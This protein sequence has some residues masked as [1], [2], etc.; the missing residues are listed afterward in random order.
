V[1]LLLDA[2]LTCR[3]GTRDEELGYRLVKLHWEAAHFDAVKIAYDKE[4]P[5]RKGLI[6]RVRGETSGDQAEFL[7][8]IL[9]A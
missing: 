1:L 5:K 3:S 9:R 6:E 8:A 7:V 4:Y 2:L